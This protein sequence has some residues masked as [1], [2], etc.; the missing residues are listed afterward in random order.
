MKYK[1]TR[2]G[3]QKNHNPFRRFGVLLRLLFSNLWPTQMC[4]CA[5]A[6][7]TRGNTSSRS[8]LIAKRVMLV[9]QARV[10]I[11]VHHISTPQRSTWAIFVSGLSCRPNGL[12]HFILCLW[13]L[14]VNNPRNLVGICYFNNTRQSL[15]GVWLGVLGH[16]PVVI[17]AHPYSNIPLTHTQGSTWPMLSGIGHQVHVQMTYVMF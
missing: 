11:S 13:T 9:G 3:W 16:C 7:V 4:A 2:P 8:H 5:C 10:W 17:F 15:Q 1:S 12:L 6:C 14:R